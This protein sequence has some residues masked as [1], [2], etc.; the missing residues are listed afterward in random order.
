MKRIIAI[1][2]L[3][4]TTCCMVFANDSIQREVTITKDFTP[5][6]R[7]AEKINSLP[8]IGTPDFERRAVNYCF[9][10][11][12]TQVSTIATNVNIPYSPM[13]ENIAKRHRGYFDL[14]IGTYLAMSAN[15]GYR[16]VDT[17]KDQLNIGL[18]FTS[19]NWDIPVN[20]HATTIPEE[21]T[22]QNFYDARAGLHYAHIFDNNITVAL[23]G[24]Y[25]YLDF[26]YYG[27]SGDPIATLPSHPFQK[28]HNFMAE[29]KVDNSEA[30]QYDYEQ[31]HIT[32]GYSLYRNNNG[33]YL[34]DASSEHHAYIDGAYSFMLDDYWCVGGDAELDYLLYNGLIPAGSDIDDLI[35]ADNDL[36]TRT[37]YVFMARI[38]PH[39]DWRANRM[40]FR[41]GIKVDISAGDGTI[42]RFA[43]DIHFN[44]EFVENYFVFASIDGGKQLHTWNDISQYCIYF[45][46]SQR[47]PSS[48]TPLDSH[49]GVKLHFIPE[50]SL[51]LHGGYEI[52][53]DAL[54]QS[55]GHSSRAISWQTIDANCFK[56]GARIDANISSYVTL[57]LDA[58]YRLWKHDGTAITYNRP[59][60]E[61]NAHVTIHP[62]NQFDV[63]LGYNMQLDRNFG[64][65]GSLSDIHNLQASVIY[66]PLHW[67]SIKA[68]GNNLLNRRYDYYYGLPAPRIQAMIGV[69]IK[70]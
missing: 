13:Y 4:F 68:H 6:V 45:D 51:S 52:V 43:P 24:A 62:H 59:R 48:Y 11:A 40:H 20:S 9:D 42:F 15:A 22:R 65:Y 47:I 32:G 3:L 63:E 12:A 41:G 17:K 5:I 19:L 27:V 30:Y 18:Q 21:K 33:T 57:T 67:L 31:W 10:A 35:A 53:A 38:N 37:E 64:V 70:L 39:A 55:I 7:D 54:F 23:N 60:W 34:P 16:F 26:N 29:I 58:A 25:R 36:N 46:P 69:G 61:G 49:L 8:P 1:T 66:S 44:W 50:L 56:T 28:V 2:T 14:N